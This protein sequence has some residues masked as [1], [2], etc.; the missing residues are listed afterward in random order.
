MHPLL[1]LLLARDVDFFAI[2]VKNVA[3]LPRE[4]SKQRRSDTM[5]W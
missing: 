5:P 1:D 2:D 3:I 4:A